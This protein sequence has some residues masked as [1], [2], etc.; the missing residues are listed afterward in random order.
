MQYPK[1]SP[2]CNVSMN[3]PFSQ[4]ELGI[5]LGV[6]S[7]NGFTVAQGSSMTIPCSEVGAMFSSYIPP[8]FSGPVIAEAAGYLG[9]GRRYFPIQ[10][11]D[12]NGIVISPNGLITL[13]PGSYTMSLQPLGSGS[14]MARNPESPCPSGVQDVYCSPVLPIVLLEITGTNPFGRLEYTVI[15]ESI[16]NPGVTFTVSP[17]TPTQYFIRSDANVPSRLTITKNL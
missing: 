11:N 10:N 12:S 1:A 3:G 2:N 15:E 9:L 6:R 7:Q 16:P 17:T 5:Q 8:S 14:L 13:Q 4:Q